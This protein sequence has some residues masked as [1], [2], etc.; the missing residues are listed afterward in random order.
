[1]KDNETV[2]KE[3]KEE[4]FLLEGKRDKIENFLEINKEMNVF[5]KELLLEQLMI[6]ARYIDI[7]SR[8]I[9]N[10]LER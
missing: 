3:L 4:R 8:R 5:H 1:M 6:I 9:S 2:L 7:L 10:L